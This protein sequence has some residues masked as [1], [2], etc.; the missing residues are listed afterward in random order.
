MINKDNRV[1]SDEALSMMREHKFEEMMDK[2]DKKYNYPL[3]IERSGDYAVRIGFIYLAKALL[4]MKGDS[5]N[6]YK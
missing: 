3:P 4:T 1:H 2:I 6:I 5:V